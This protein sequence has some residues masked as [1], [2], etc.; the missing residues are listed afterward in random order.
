LA[1]AADTPFRDY[2]R[3]AIERRR[4]RRLQ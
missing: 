4:R 3:Y 1:T 2:M